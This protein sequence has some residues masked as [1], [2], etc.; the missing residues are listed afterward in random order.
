MNP[1][2]EL[3]ALLNQTFSWNK[4]RIDCLVGML[5]ALLSTRNMN[6]TE[7]AIAFPSEAQPDSRYRRIQRF[8]SDYLTD[9][10]KFSLFIMKLFDFLTRD[11]HLF[12]TE[13]IGNGVKKH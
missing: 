2:K 6:L 4:A 13:Q 12:S 1:T 3:S 7:L 8:I 10:D 5:I 11:Y 9:F